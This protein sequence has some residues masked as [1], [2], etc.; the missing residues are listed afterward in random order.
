MH[1]QPF[2]K[3]VR[4]LTPSN[5]EE[6]WLFIVFVKQREHINSRFWIMFTWTTWIATKLE[7]SLIFTSIL[8]CLKWL[9][10]RSVSNVLFYCLKNIH[11]LSFMFEN[12]YCGSLS[13]T[14]N[15]LFFSHSLK[16]TIL[17]CTCSSVT[18]VLNLLTCSFGFND[19]LVISWSLLVG[20]R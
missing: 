20:G 18:D 19:E 2:Y 13:F 12:S 11:Y 9:S 3:F 8:R 4:K 5:L 1:W 6:T 16:F 10:D 15:S 14:R 17:F 7:P